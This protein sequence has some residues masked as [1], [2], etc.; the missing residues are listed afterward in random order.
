MVER[1]VRI[2]K[3]TSSNLVIST[4][5][6]LKRTPF[7][8]TVLGFFCCRPTLIRYFYDTSSSTCKENAADKQIPTAYKKA[9]K[10]KLCRTEN[11]DRPFPYALSFAL[12]RLPIWRVLERRGA[13]EPLVYSSTRHSAKMCFCLCYMVEKIAYL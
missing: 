11:K 4:S 3:V 2:A 7:E 8:R 9:L 5:P 12:F 6:N 13:A 10:L 1:C